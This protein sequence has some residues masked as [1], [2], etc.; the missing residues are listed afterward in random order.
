MVPP[1]PVTTDDLERDRVL[2]QRI[3]LFKWVEP[4]HLDIPEGPGFEGFLMFAQQGRDVVTD[5][6]CSFDGIF[7]QNF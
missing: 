5:I 2:S 3:A 6:Q 7:L 1:R 4:H